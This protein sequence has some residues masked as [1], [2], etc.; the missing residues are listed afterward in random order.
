[1][2]QYVPVSACSGRVVHPRFIAPRTPP[3]RTS[4]TRA[5][6]RSRFFS[7][8]HLVWTIFP[9][10]AS[11]ATFLSYSCWV[12]TFC[13]TAV[14][15]VLYG[16]IFASCNIR[17]LS[18]VGISSSRRQRYVSASCETPESRERG[19]MPL[20]LL[21]GTLLQVDRT[22]Y[23]CPPRRKRRPPLVTSLAMMIGLTR[24]ELDIDDGPISSIEGL[25]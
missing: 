18:R 23:Y 4:T 6:F 2:L 25:C 20:R 1:M 7:D 15:A 22:R 9:S 24:D 16:R 5:T 10:S 21:F 11:C 8:R 13:I 17:V 3:L 19:V 14:L 12:S